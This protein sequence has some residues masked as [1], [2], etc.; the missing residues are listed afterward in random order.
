MGKRGNVMIVRTFTTGGGILY[1][2]NKEDCPCK[3]SK[4]SIF[5]KLYY[6][7]AK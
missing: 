4:R 5:G 6:L 3:D 7:E 1:I 2:G